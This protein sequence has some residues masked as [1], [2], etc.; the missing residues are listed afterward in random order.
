MAEAPFCDGLGFP[1][2]PCFDEQGRLHVVDVRG[3]TVSRVSPAGRDILATTH[4]GPNGAAF[5]PDGNLY[6]VNNGGLLWCDD[7]HAYGSAEGNEGGWVDRIRPDGTVERLYTECAGEPLH[8]CNDIAFDSDGNFYFTDPEHGTRAHRPPGYVCWASLDGREIRRVAEGLLLPNGIGITADGRHLIVVET[9][10]RT[11][12][13]FDIDGPGQLS[14]GRPLAQLPDGCLPDGF[15]IDSRGRII[16]CAVGGGG[17]FVF[18]PDGAL[19]RHI[20]MTDADT[21]NCA[22]G[23]PQFCTLYFTQGVQGRVAT[24]EWDVPGIPLFS[25]SLRG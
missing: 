6:V 13:R 23:G 19:E 9:L 21:T 7:G 5:G 24:L 22:F 25:T 14:N 12:W 8:A 17:V 10:P 11:L 16:T 15:A 2:G 18:R 20:E 4:G 1:E 3:G